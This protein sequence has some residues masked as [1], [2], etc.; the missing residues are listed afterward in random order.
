[1]AVAR[2]I[3]DE[4]D[5]ILDVILESGIHVKSSYSPKDL[6]A[7]GFSYEKD[8][9]DPGEY[10][11]TRGIHALGYRS[12]AWTTRQYTGFG[13][14]QE[15][16]ERFKLM[17]SHGQTGLNVA[18]DLPTQMGYDSDDSM[19]EGEVG[20]VGMAV[21]TL[22]DFEIAFKDIRLDKIGSGLTINA[23]ASIMLAMYQAV[24]EK[25]GYDP[26]VISATPQNDILK[27]MV[28]RGAWIF[29][30]EPAVKLIGDTIE[31]SMNVLP[32]T[33]PVSVCGYHIRESGA[34]P[35][36]EIAC[37]ILI[38]NAYIDN[39]LARGHDVDAFVGRFSFNLNVFGNMWEQVAKFR[40]AR[41]LWAR[42]L[43]EK[44]NVKKPQNLFLRGLFGG[45]G[46]G[47]TKAQP[48]NNIM[49][50]A[51]YAL[52]AALSGAQTTALCS[53]DEAYTIPTPHSALLSLRT[54]QLLMDEMGLRDTVDPLAGSYFI[55]TLTKEMEQKIEEEMD[56]INKFGG[57][58]EGVAKGYIQRLVARQAFEVE[59]GL[60]SGELKKV[61]VNIYKEGESMEVELHEYN[62]ESAEKQIESLHAVKRERSEKDVTRTLKELEAATRDGKNVMPYLVACCKAYAS[63]GEM[64]GIFREIFG[65]F[66]EPSLF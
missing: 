22:R 7:M 11:Y 54:L 8:V 29:P 30:V 6:D 21:D 24:A 34:T 63:V 12:R 37:A 49:R 59:K 39:V 26:K 4:K 25:Y 50:G 2:Y 23:V 52:V 61:G 18:F 10:P 31:Y 17:I 9:A 20:R 15:T 65:E 46:Y 43:K 45:G 16:N 60:E 33:N 62:W 47:L 58:I 51:Y 55:E 42:N 40:A 27:E 57:I 66:N 19:S 48:E 14:P 3:K 38:A 41:K 64:T 44:Y 56:K 1:M 13:T 36:Q 28:G 32:R 35:A 5:Q 53:Y